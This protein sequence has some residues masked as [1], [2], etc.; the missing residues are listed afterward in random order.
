MRKICKSC[1]AE[2]HPRS[3][4][5]GHC[6]S[7]L[8]VPYEPPRSKG[9]AIGSFFI[10]LGIWLASQTVLSVAFMIPVA[11]SVFSDRKLMTMDYDRIYDA[12]MS[13]VSGYLTVISIL[14]SVL[15]IAVVF[16]IFSIRQRR[17]DR[18]GVFPQKN[19]FREVGFRK[20]PVSVCV[21]AVV[22]GAALNRVVTYIVDVIPWPGFFVDSFNRTYDPLLGGDTSF[23]LVVL[24]TVIMAPITEEL[25][26]RGIACSRFTPAFPNVV[27]VIASSLIFGIAHGTPIAVIYASAFGVVLACTFL[28]HRS[29]YPTMLA[30][31]GFN[32]T[33]TLLPDFAG[34]VTLD[35]AIFS[36]CA[37]VSVAGIWFVT[38]KK[39]ETLPEAGGT[40]ETV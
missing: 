23:I 37:A 39:K 31:L 20:A 3:N 26:F 18:L 17:R 38:K 36:I 9:R 19:L 30:H 2:A 22:L 24:S 25:L 15:F 35:L 12:L 4:F 21:S 5:C 6:G 34:S 13:R 1:G 27:A 33:A 10:Y 28:R 11:I 29:L 16:L 7:D 14:S 40:N 32:L 8:L